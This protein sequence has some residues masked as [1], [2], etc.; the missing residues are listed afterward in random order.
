MKG[1]FQL[2]I[3]SASLF[4]TLHISSQTLLK[5][6]RVF[7]GETVHTNWVVLVEANK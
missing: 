2:E 6:D 5:P 1:I 4:F 3:I 7:D